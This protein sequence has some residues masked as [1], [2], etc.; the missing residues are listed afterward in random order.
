MSALPFSSR[1]SN[2]IILPSGDQ[3]GEPGNRA[4]DFVSL[5]QL[6]PSLAEAQTS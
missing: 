5:T 3:R 6:E 2:T 4:T 1:P